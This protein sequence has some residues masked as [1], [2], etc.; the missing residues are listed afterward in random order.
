M[1]NSFKGLKIFQLSEYLLLALFAFVVP[2]S[3]R[4]ATFI[5]IAIFTA[6]VLKGIF[7]EGFKPNPYQYQNKFTYIVFIAFWFLYA[8][9][10]LY[11][12]NTAEARIQIGKKLPFFIFPI[13]FLCSNLSYLTKDR[14]RTIM[15]C[16]VF[17][18]LILFTV[19]LLWAGYDVIF[20]DAEIKR[21][22][23]P[24]NFFKTNNYEIFFSIV[25][26]AYFSAFTC[27]ALVFC[28]IELFY[29]KKIG[30]KLFNI[31]ASVLLI[32]IPFFLT[33]RSGMLCTALMLSII[34]IWITFV[35][36]RKYIGILSGIIMVILLIIGYLAF[37][38]SI[39][40][41]TNA[42][43][44]IKE[45]KGDI[46]LT[47]RH[48]TRNA[49]YN[50]IVY[51]AGVGD[52]NKETMKSFQ[53]YKDEMI[54][55]IIPS[56]ESFLNTDN[57]KNIFSD[58]VCEYEHMYNKYAYKYADSIINKNKYDNSPT[59]EYLSEYRIIKHCMKHELNTHNQF[60]DTIIAVGSIGLLLFLM[61]LI[62]PIYLGIKNKKNDIVLISLVFIIAFNSLFESVLE[63]QMGIMFFVFFY[64]I[65]FHGTF[66]QQ[67][68]DNRS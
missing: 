29:V 30:L 54:S 57:N 26:R 18:I 56:N 24:H 11:S 41:Y 34:W 21:L 16:F 52:R 39:E 28:C 6:T 42:L 60:A 1:L 47:I 31:L 8:I 50:N 55:K 13:F 25:H 19:N 59:K 14:V 45:G 66:C 53:K 23:S 49:L 22:K 17:G 7:E 63:R 36:K 58:S 61:M 68:I 38:K 64:F 48:A 15:Y 4:I 40:R 37:P 62:I 35:I 2:F 27:I 51:G 10:F 20:E 67:G 65:L 46:R 44:N 33:S 9:S 3:W 5:I 12:E 43:N 32:F